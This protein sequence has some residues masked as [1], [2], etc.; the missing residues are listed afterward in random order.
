MAAP[1]A[2]RAG[3]MAM[4]TVAS[5]AG[6]RHDSSVT[7]RWSIDPGEDAELATRVFEL[8]GLR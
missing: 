6:G 1:A 5:G 3:D 2:G 8:L 4:T 7:W